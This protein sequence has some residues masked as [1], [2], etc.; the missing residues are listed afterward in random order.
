M[1]AFRITLTGDGA[2]VDDTKI[3]RLL[4]RNVFKTVTQQALAHILRL[5]LVDLAAERNGFKFGGQFLLVR[6][7]FD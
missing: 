6:Y 4:I 5:V 7:R 2:C 3:G 1:T